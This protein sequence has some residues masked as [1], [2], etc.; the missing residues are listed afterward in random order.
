MCQLVI[1]LDADLKAA[2]EISAICL[3][4]EHLQ[5]CS[6]CA[7]RKIFFTSKFSYGLFC[8][9]TNKLKLGQQ[10]GGGLL[11]TNHLEQSL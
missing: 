10:I 1:A 9:P 11:I 7:H 3:H 4:W 2:K 5:Q 6:I 8:N